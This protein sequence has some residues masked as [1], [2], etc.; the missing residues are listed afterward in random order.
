MKN[1]KNTEYQ[2]IWFVFITWWLAITGLHYWILLNSG[3]SSPHALYDALIHNALLSAFSFGSMFTIRLYKPGTIGI[4]YLVLSCCMLAAVWLWSATTILAEIEPAIQNSYLSPS[5]VIRFVTGF[6][7]LLLFAGYGWIRDYMKDRDAESERQQQLELTARSAE[8]ASI[9][10][11]LQPHFLF[12]TLNSINALLA[13]DPLQARNMVI[14]L[15]QFLR[16]SLK[17]DDTRLQTFREE[18][19]LIN[20]YLEIE[21]VR[22]GERLDIQVNYD[23]DADECRVPPFIL[24][25]LIE[26]AIKFGVYGQLNKVIIRVSAKLEENFL[27]IR[28]RNPFDPT[29][30]NPGKGTGFGLDSVRRRLLLLFGRNDLL[31]TS[32]DSGNFNVSMK[33]PQN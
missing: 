31:V 11:Q 30:Q 8:L 16:E 15:S 25:P 4:L 23:A 20:L 19:G 1:N 2:Y 5:A 10:Q 28:I 27:L 3:I 24:Q 6:L 26:N 32:V 12:N 29:E 17:Q 7:V 22:F 33:I 13:I 14:Q 18:I 21:K 9:R